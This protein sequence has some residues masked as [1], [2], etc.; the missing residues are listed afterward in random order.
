M[1]TMNKK[2][3][4]STEEVGRKLHLDYMY[5]SKD[6]Y[7]KILDNTNTLLKHIRKQSLDIDKFFDEIITVIR[8]RLWIREVTVA[9]FN[10]E[11]SCYMYRYMG[12]LRNDT[13]EAHKSL[14]YTKEELVNPNV[15]KSREISKETILFLAEDNPYGEGEA[16]TY[17]RPAMLESMRRSAEDSIEGDYFDIWIRGKND[18]ILGWIEIS[19][20]ID[21]KFPTIESLKWIEILASLA[22]LAIGLSN[23]KNEK[24]RRF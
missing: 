3:T 10:P 4:V 24:G 8:R 23:V 15:Y 17:N 18:D 21:Y 5:S 9:L 13:W 20:T 7:Q 19:G 22:G 16:K 1:M 14:S 12:G 6:E 11:K 2:Q